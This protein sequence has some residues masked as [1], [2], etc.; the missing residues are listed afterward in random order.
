MATA[1]CSLPP[2]GP[3]CALGDPWAG[4]GWGVAGYI[5]DR[6]VV[7]G[8]IA[9]VLGLFGTGWYLLVLGVWKG[10]D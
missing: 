5:H 2:S 9:I 7:A 1:K 6:S 8:V 10:G 4:L 3:N